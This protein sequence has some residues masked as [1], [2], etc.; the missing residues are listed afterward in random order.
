[1]RGR[2]LPVIPRAPR[3]QTGNSLRKESSRSGRSPRSQGCG[4]PGDSESEGRDW[5]IQE[6]PSLPW[7]HL[8]FTYPGFLDFSVLLPIS[9]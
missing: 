9:T 6:D 7:T 3:S 5:G 2:A 8:P 1:M 4:R